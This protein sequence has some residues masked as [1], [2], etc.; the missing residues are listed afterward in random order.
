MRYDK[1]R[2]IGIHRKEQT[3]Y[4]SRLLGIALLVGIPALL[5]TLAMVVFRQASKQLTLS[6]EYELTVEE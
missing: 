2:E 4:K 5:A 6:N 3:M 1:R